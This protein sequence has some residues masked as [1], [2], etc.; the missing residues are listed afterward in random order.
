MIEE[1]RNTNQIEMIYREYR[2]DFIFWITTNFNCSRDEARIIYQDSILALRRNIRSSKE[3]KFQSCIKSFL[4]A[5]GKTK[6]KELK[7]IH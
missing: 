3:N 4:Y 5:T 2:S 7:K 6:L 1:I